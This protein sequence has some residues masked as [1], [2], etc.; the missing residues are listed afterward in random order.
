MASRLFAAVF[1]AALVLALALGGPTGSVF[2]HEHRAVG[3]YSFVVGW[4]GEPAISNQPN[5]VSLELMFFENGVPEM[6]EENEDE[7][8]GGVPVEGADSTLKVEVQTA[9]G[10]QSTDLDLEPAFGEVGVY[11]STSII[12]TLPGD[13]TFI[14][15]GTIDGTEINETFTSG[16][17][18]FS[19]VDDATTLEFPQPSADADS[20]SDA[21]D[22]EDD[23]DNMG[24]IVGG[25]AIVLAVIAGGLSIYALSRSRSA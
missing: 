24:V 19:T 3:N 6:T 5:A 15:T 12:P 21:S 17:E 18:T 10:A 13:Y 4:T 9:G 14:F 11:E 16:P 22:S 25:I 1:A 7:D 20:S 23:D 8:L 2:A